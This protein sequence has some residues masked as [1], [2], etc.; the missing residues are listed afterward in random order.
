MP[1]HLDQ[2]SSCRADREELETGI[3]QYR[4]WVGSETERP[5]AFW[6]RQQSSIT[7]AIDRRSSARPRL[8]WALAS[9]ACLAIV[10]TALIIERAP[11]A[12]VVAMDPDHELLLDIERALRRDVPEALAPAELLIEEIRLA[13]EANMDRTRGERQ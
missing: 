9:I 10:A 1:E 5:D 4:Q 6:I 8:I 11:Q 12:P 7:R 3:G 2:C 13:V